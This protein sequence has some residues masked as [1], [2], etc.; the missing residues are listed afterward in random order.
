MP[1]PREVALSSVAG[2]IA[3]D[4]D[5]I[6]EHGHPEHYVD[7]I[8]AI[9]EFR[10]RDAVRGFFAEL[11]A[12]IPDYDMEIEQVIDGADAVAVRWR[13]GGTFEG[14]PFQGIRPS[15][16]RVEIHGVD[17]FEVEGDHI[18]RNTVYYDGAAF[19]RQIGLLP[20][21]GSLA[22]RAALRLFN[23]RVRVGRLVR[24]RR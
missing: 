11:F 12:A 7:H 5:R 4:P 18:L 2:A 8:V 6:V 10:G 21:A 14:A 22:D 9:G 16:R 23:A 24:R 15:G 17:V 20:R 3:R 19:A 13:A 1:T